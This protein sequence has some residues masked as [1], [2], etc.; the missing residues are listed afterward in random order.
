MNITAQLDVIDL[1]TLARVKTLSPLTVSDTTQD[2]LISQLITDVSARI[3]RHIGWHLSAVARVETY[4]MRQHQNMLRLDAKPVSLM[5]A[6]KYSGSDLSTADW[7]AH[8][9][10]ATTA[11][12]V[13]LAGGWIR[14]LTARTSDPGFCQVSYTAGFG[15]AASNVIT[16]FPELSQACELQVKYLHERLSTL[17]GDVTTGAGG[18][19]QFNNAYMMHPE[20]RA[21]LAMHKKGSV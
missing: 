18:G 7:T 14:F 12:S 2:V 17:G 15:V 5:T 13:N 3:S 10:L 20:V 16:D 21:L 11:Y 9:A 4:M 19:T 1:T 6:V 8:T